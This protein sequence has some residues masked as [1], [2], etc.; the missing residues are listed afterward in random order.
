[1]GNFCP[2]ISGST[3]LIIT[4]PYKPVGLLADIHNRTK[5]KMCPGNY[6]QMGGYRTRYQY[7]TIHANENSSQNVRCRY[8]SYDAILL[9]LGPSTKQYFEV[10]TLKEQPKNRESSFVP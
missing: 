6:Y 7:I 10:M 2:P 8:G 9:G 1:M 3:T 5:F 4:L